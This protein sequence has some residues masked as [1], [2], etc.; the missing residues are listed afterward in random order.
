MIIASC[1]IGCS[2]WYYKDWKYNFYPADIS[3]KHFLSYYADT[4]KTVEVNNTFYNFPSSNSMMNW[5]NQTPDDFIFSLKVNKHYTHTSRLHTSKD[6]LRRFY[7]YEDVLK[8][9][10]GWFLFQFP[11]SYDFNKEQLS[12]I[13]TLLDPLYNNVVEFRH[14]TWWNPYVFDAFTSAN[15][16]FCT[17]SGFDVPDDL[18]TLNN[19]AYIRFHGD[20]TYSAPY[21]KKELLLWKNKIIRTDVTECWAY[22]NNTAHGFAPHNAKLL[23]TLLT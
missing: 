11:K 13:T 5:Y 17:V 7:T 21:S 19:K 14:H 22:F 2:G 9:K 20:S 15:I 6:D 16:T 8:N 1:F 4:F 3:S 18:I 10:M 12:R 23:K